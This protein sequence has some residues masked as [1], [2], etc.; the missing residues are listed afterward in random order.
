MTQTIL[1]PSLQEQIANHRETVANLS[2]RAGVCDAVGLRN[3]AAHWRSMIAAAESC[4][5]A[6]ERR[7]ADDAERRVARALRSYVERAQ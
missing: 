4:I 2:K 1:K 3:S 7:M 5:R 6:C